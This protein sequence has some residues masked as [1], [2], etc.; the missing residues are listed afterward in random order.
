MDFSEF[1]FFLLI[2]SIIVTILSVPSLIFLREEP[3]SPPS[4]L[5]RDKDSIV[6]MSMVDSLKSL[7]KN[8][9][10]MFMF[11]SFNFLYG[12]YSAIAAVITSFTTPYGYETSDVSI[13]CVVF[14]VSGI[15]NSFF[16][17]TLLDKH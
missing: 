3:P 16:I 9:N 5:L 13:I 15:L 7:F 8:R 2:Q 1:E 11:G 17:G 10:Y 12:L 6:E 4:V 14:S